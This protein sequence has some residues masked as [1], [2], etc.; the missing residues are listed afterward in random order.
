MGLDPGIRTGVKV[1]VV[2][3]T[4]K[5]LGHQHGLPTRA[6]QGLGG[7][8]PHPGQAVRGPWRQPDRHRQRHG[9][10]RNRQAGGRPHQAPGAARAW[11]PD[12]EGRGQRGRGFG[13]LS[14]RVRQQGIAGAGREPAR[15]RVHRPPP[16]RPAGRAGQDR[17]QEHWRGPVPARRQP[18]RAGAHR[19]SPW[20]KTA[21]TAWVWTS[22]PPSAP[23]LSRV[24]G[25]EHDGGQQHRALARCTMAPSA[26]ASNCWTWRAWG[27][28]TFE[29]AAGFLRIR[30]GDNPLDFSGV[31]P[32]TYPVV[33]KMLGADRQ[34]R[35]GAHRQVRRAALRS[36]PSCSPT[37]SSA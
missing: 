20:S 22:T 21:S 3:D 1:A 30:D 28:K 2:S 25:P 37:R 18:E 13:V 33:Q 16:A 32:E 5:V 9:Q 7:L 11:C 34:D 17:P 8:D 4:G 23:L 14:L 24:S 31:H 27:A 19:W 15:R 29:Q 26:T 35:A 6:A 36:S 10:P 12:R